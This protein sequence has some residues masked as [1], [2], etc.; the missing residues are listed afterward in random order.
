MK[1]RKLQFWAS[2][3]EVTDYTTVTTADLAKWDDNAVSVPKGEFEQF[4][5]ITSFVFDEIM[6][7][8]EIFWLLYPDRHQPTAGMIYDSETDIHYIFI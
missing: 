2:C 8:P 6:E 1:T 5:N 7:H 3:T 4:A